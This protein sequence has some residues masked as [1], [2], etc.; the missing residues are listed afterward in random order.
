[1]AKNKDFKK[2]SIK[3]TSRIQIKD[4][5]PDHGK[6]KPIFSFFHMRYGK[7]YCL[8]KCE[9]DDKSDLATTL[10]KLSQITWNEIASSYRKFYGYEHIP[11]EKFHATEFPE[12]VTPDVKKLLVFSYSHGGRMAGIQQD[13]IFHIFLVGNN[14][15]K[16]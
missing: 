11:I 4:S 5:L 6:L 12:I 7:I 16:H 9:R 14:L 3:S 8:S 10:L 2:P 15:Y 13:N 1:M